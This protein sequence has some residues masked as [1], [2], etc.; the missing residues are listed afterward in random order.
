MSTRQ[1]ST[2]P[3]TRAFQLQPEQGEPIPVIVTL[4][5]D[6]SVSIRRRY[7]RVEQRIPLLT[8]LSPLPASRPRTRNWPIGIPEAAH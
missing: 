2:R 4:H 6:A 5:P 3:V 1:P 7:G 8:L